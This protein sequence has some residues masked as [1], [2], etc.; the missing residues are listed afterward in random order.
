MLAKRTGF[1]FLCFA[2]KENRWSA[3]KL[4]FFA[5]HGINLHYTIGNNKQKGLH[6]YGLV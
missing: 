5:L 4:E 6:L 2:L 3:V 1:P